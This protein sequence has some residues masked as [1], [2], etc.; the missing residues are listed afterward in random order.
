MPLEIGTPAPDFTLLNQSREPVSLDDLKGARSVIVF[1]PFAFTSTCE[2][3]LCQI[4]DE[5]PL[6]SGA[7]ARVV[8]ITCNTLHANRVWADQ[9]GFQFDIL[10]DWWPHGFVSM[11]YDTFNEGY[12]Y[13]ERTT[14]FLDEEGVITEVTKSENL[15]EARSFDEYRAALG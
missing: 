6:F 2:S 15:G 1:I 11:A 5:Y 3:E 12:G 4:R 8:A 9:Q 10:S 7:G 13:P 14:Y